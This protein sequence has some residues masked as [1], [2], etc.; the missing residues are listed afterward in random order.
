MAK[1]PENSRR[2]TRAPSSA[3][4]GIESKKSRESGGSA[5]VAAR[6]P[7]NGVKPMQVGQSESCPTHELHSIGF[8]AFDSTHRMG[9]HRPVAPASLPALLACTVKPARRVW[10]L[11]PGFWRHCATYYG[12]NPVSDHGTHCFTN[13]RIPLAIQQQRQRCLC[14]AQPGPALFPE[15]ALQ[16]RASRSNARVSVEVATIHSA[17]TFSGL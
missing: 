15:P 2:T 10:L 9:E 3:P 5:S 17:T 4:I 14:L 12:A 1:K 11:P 8:S 13:H 6:A 7:A 16:G